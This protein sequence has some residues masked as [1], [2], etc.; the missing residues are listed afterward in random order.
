M[1]V[2]VL[3]LGAALS[4]GREE[5][6]S[7]QRSATP[8]VAVPDPAGAGSGTPVASGSGTPVASG[9][10]AASVTPADPKAAKNLWNNVILPAFNKKCASCHAEPRFPVAQRGSLTIFIYDSM[11][12]L[13]VDGGTPTDNKLIRKMTNLDHHDG[14]VQCKAAEA[15]CSDVVQWRKLELGADADAGAATVGS[16]SDSPG[17]PVDERPA[18]VARITSAGKIYGWAVNKDDLTAAVNVKVYLDGPIGT[19]TLAVTTPADKAGDDGNHA[20][21]HG[22]FV[23]VPAT[24]LTGVDRPLYLYDD[25]DVLLTPTP[26]TF[27][28]WTS[29]MVGKNYFDSHIAGM[30]T[31]SCDGCHP[32]AYDYFYGILVTK[33]PNEGGTAMNNSVINKPATANGTAHSGGNK[34][35]GISG[36]VCAEFQK[37]W[38][39]EFAPK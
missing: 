13:L 15:P 24:Y 19:G 14:G 30:I 11:R 39:V 20:G 38:D 25:K 37:W 21:N 9:S 32:S 3:G 7:S 17:G 1:A 12:K 35:G 23:Q 33:G 34:C 22:F 6:K 4:C 28:A 26:E 2:A 18:A 36:G 31:S 27:K 16:G 10:T 8:V 29:G 5:K